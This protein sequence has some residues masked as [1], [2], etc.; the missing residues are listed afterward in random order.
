MF[1][2]PS[3]VAE[4]VRRHAG[5]LRARLVV[6]HDAERNDVMTLHCELSGPAPDSFAAAV[7]ESLREV[8]KLRGHVVLKP[9]G[10]LANDGKVIEDLRK[11]D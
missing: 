6:T 4:V 3:Q 7:E 5:I 8:C 10:A 1:V 9:A 2:H 11:Y